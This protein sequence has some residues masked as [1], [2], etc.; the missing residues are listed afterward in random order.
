MKNDGTP[1]GGFWYADGIRQSDLPAMARLLALVLVGVA[2]NATGKVT[3]SHT[4]LTKYTGMSR[5]SVARQLATLEAAGWVRRN[6][7]PVWKARNEHA[8][9]EYTCVIP[10]GVPTKASPTR[11]LGL[12]PQGTQA[13]PRVGLGLVPQ[14]DKASPRVGHS[15]TSTKGAASRSAGAT[16]TRPADLPH[17]PRPD[18]TALLQHI[19]DMFDSPQAA[20]DLIAREGTAIYGEDRPLHELHHDRNV[21]NSALSSIKNSQTWGH[22]IPGLLPHAQKETV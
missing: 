21:L 1:Q 16:H 2:D 13:S 19:H 8:M 22:D 6:P 18:T 7:P 17:I 4:L 15:T 14:S 11:G 20:D 10:A 9:T 3:I 5:S 12:V